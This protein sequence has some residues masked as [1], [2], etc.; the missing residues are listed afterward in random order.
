MLSSTLIP[1]D[2]YN[3]LPIIEEQGPPSNVHLEEIGKLLVSHALNG[4]LGISLL[5][6]HSILQDQSFLLHT[7]L[8]GAPALSSD[9]RSVGNLKGASF[10]LHDCVFQAYEYE[11]SMNIDDDIQLVFLE[12]F[13]EYLKL[14]GLERKIALSRLDLTHPKLM[15]HCEEDDAG[16]I[17][18]VCEV[19]SEDIPLEE[20][21][22]WKFDWCDGTVVPVITR[23][24]ARTS[25][26][27]HKKK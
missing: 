11:E 26:G 21:T 14:H 12:K 7:G 23:G 20:A 16:V 15:E 17:T 9:V 1:I 13:A 19:T 4:H 3:S 27:D 5:H 8:R 2:L 22:E 6:R 24:C 25:S 18:H 10:F